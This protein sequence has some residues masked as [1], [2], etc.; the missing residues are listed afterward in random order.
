MAESD[1]GV[2]RFAPTELQRRLGVLALA[3]LAWA[4]GFAALSR[5]GTWTPFA[6]AGPALAVAALLFGAVSAAALRP[7][8]GTVGSGLFVG[9]LMVVLTRVAYAV[10]APRL[11]W[12]R[13]ATSELLDLLNV[14]GFSPG[15]RAGLIA[16]IA[17]SEEV[18]FRGALPGSHSA[19]GSPRLIGLARA[20]LVQVVIFAA[21]YALPTLALGS[22]LLVVCAFLCAIVWGSMR[23][24]SGSLVAPIVAHVI[25][26][27]GVLVVWPLA[28]IQGTQVKGYE[29]AR[30][31]F[32]LAKGNPA[33]SPATNQEVYAVNELWVRPPLATAVLR[34]QAHPARRTGSGDLLASSWSIQLQ[35]RT[36]AWSGAFAGGSANPGNESDNPAAGARTVPQLMPVGVVNAQVFAFVGGRTDDGSGRT[37]W[38]AEVKTPDPSNNTGASIDFIEDLLYGDGHFQP[39]KPGP[40]IGPANPPNPRVQGPGDLNHDGAVQCAMTQTGDDVTTRQLH[41]IEFGGGHLVY[42][43]ASRFQDATTESGSKFKRFCDISQWVDLGQQFGGNIGS[44]VSA[45]IVARPASISIF[46]VAQA[47]SQYRTFHAVRFANGSW[48]PVDDVLAKR[49]GAG[50]IGTSQPFNVAA[51]ICPTFPLAG[52][53]Q[54]D[55]LLYVQWRDNDFAN[56]GE[57]TSSARDWQFGPV[58]VHGNYSSTFRL[59]GVI[60]GFPPERLHKLLHFSIGAR[61]FPG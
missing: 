16:V 1:T 15:A 36:G 40:L 42:S 31:V 39:N 20:D 26:D 27:L 47:G 4:V 21:G 61:P 34:A 38:L 57:I 19:R 24:A 44:I 8:P 11:P 46:F 53:P 55:A 12:A 2:R 43:V 14:G 18:L 29:P 59:P 48:R 45:S 35:D 37:T 51:G 23:L 10:V 7:S 58:I 52:Q 33:L 28:T 13:S 17:A 32:H 54:E 3:T 49:D 5:L 41:M 22:V 60:R 25:W 50:A 56:F 6:L 9:V 30:D